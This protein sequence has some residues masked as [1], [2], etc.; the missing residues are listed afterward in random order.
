MIFIKIWGR[1]SEDPS[2]IPIA[3]VWTLAF[4][5]KERKHL[6]RIIYEVWDTRELP[7]WQ[8]YKAPS[9]Q[10]VLVGTWNQP[11]P[12]AQETAPQP[13]TGSPGLSKKHHPSS[14]KQSSEITTPAEIWQIA[15]EK[16]NIPFI[17]D[18]R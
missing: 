3:D 15:N 8:K 17:F 12:K 6:Q 10:V 18:L 5:E 16:E 7:G 2:L 11:H 14:R 13:V 1:S 4:E 9:L